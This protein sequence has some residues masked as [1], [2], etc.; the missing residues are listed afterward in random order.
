MIFRTVVK[1]GTLVMPG[2]GLVPG[3]VAIDDGKIAA[4]ASPR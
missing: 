2:E 4:N 1:G 3:S